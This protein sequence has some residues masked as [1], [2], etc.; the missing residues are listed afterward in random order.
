MAINGSRSVTTVL[1]TDTT[2]VIAMP[3]AKI[4][5]NPVGFQTPHMKT[6]REDPH[7]TQTSFNNGSTH[8]IKLTPLN[9]PEM[10][11]GTEDL[12]TRQLRSVQSI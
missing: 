2:T 4:K 3:D 5:T 7:T 9:S 12:E 8:T 6:Q 11:G 1:N 10:I